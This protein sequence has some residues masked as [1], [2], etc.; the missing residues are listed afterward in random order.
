MTV[1]LFGVLTDYSIF[2]MARFR[3]ML[4]E[5]EMDRVE[6]ARRRASGELLPVVVDRGPRDRPGDGLALLRA[7]R[8]PARAGAGTG[9][10]GAGGDAGRQQ[11]SSPRRS[12]SSESDAVA[13]AGRAKGRSR[14]AHTGDRR[15]CGAPRRA[16]PDPRRDGVLRLPTGGGDRPPAHPHLQPADD[17]PARG[18]VGEPRLRRGER[19]L[20]PGDRGPHH[21]RR[22]GQRRAHEAAPGQARA[23]PLPAARRRRRDRP[24][25]QPA[26][27]AAGPRAGQ[28]RRRRPLHGRVQDRSAGGPRHLRGTDDPEADARADCQRRA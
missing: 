18:F 15:A 20:R 21:G 8:L 22:R 12:P 3:A 14:R 10:H 2:F 23:T 4:E 26:R 5:E 1:L 24:G 25:R 13:A 16:P 6:A 11:R 28:E 17:E 27:E 7:A 9:D 19:R